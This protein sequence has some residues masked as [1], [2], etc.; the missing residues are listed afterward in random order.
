M[1]STLLLLVL[2]A[3]A[4]LGSCIAAKLPGDR[5]S[6]KL[7]HSLAGGKAYYILFADDILN[8]SFPEGFTEYEL[9]V[10][11]P[12]NV[13]P[14]L[15]EKV[16][17]AI[18]GSKLLAYWDFMDIPIASGCS[19]GHVMGDRP[20]R[21]CSTYP[22]YQ[23]GP[24]T[25]SNAIAKSSFHPSYAVNQ[26]LPNSTE[27]VV[28]LYPGLAFYVPFPESIKAMVQL[29]VSQLS[30]FDGIYLDGTCNAFVFEQAR[31]TELAS[32]NITFDCNGDGKADTIS[33]LV[34]QFAAYAPVFVSELRAALGDS[35]V[36]I[37][38]SAG[39]LSDS[40][41]NGITVEMESCTD[42]E[43]CTDAIVGQSAVAM[44]PQ[45]SVLWLTHSEAMPPNQ[46]C[47]RAAKFQSQYPFILAG[48]DFF[49][50]SHVVCNSTDTVL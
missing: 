27:T 3:L 44:E 21:N 24:G 46:Q 19:T 14:A 8:T 38:N 49:D 17:T 36:L 16:H 6:T 23:C 9:F 43:A 10:V 35:Y 18:P 15:I 7:P 45:V 12:Q 1:P 33:E 47:S 28:C 40:H 20:G 2:L 31:A 11:Q 13:T 32:L 34:A 39:S 48:T 22:Q 26:L 41:L 29:M 37:G 4:L 25:W 5:L 42:L 50:G 30:S